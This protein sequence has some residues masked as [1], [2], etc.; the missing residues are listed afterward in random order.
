M[1]SLALCLGAD[2]PQ[3]DSE[4]L[5][6]NVQ[7]L[8]RI[9]E[10]EPEPEPKPAITN[11]PPPAPSTHKTVGDVMDKAID[12]VSDVVGAMADAIQKVAPEVWKIMLKQ[13]YA[14]ALGNVI[15]PIGI[16]IVLWIAS[17]SF[18]SWRARIIQ[19]NGTNKDEYGWACG[20]YYGSLI[21]ISISSIVAVCIFAASIKYLI[22]PEFYAIQ[23]L[24]R[25]ILNKGQ[26][27]A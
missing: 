8:G 4:R 9:F 2:Q 14:K 25:L 19:V 26:T 6:K 1:A 18:K 17:R 27:G 23:D 3:K 22:N 16:A 10:I 7:E 20:F 21:L 12:K 5:R 11:T 15:P 24:L 13:Q